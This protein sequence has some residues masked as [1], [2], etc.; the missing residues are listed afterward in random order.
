MSIPYGSQMTV[1]VHTY[2][3]TTHPPRAGMQVIILEALSFSLSLEHWSHVLQD[4]EN[5]RASIM[6]VPEECVSRPGVNSAV[7]W[8]QKGCS[9]ENT[10]KKL[11]DQ[12]WQHIK[13]VLQPS[14]VMKNQK[15]CDQPCSG[16]LNWAVWWCFSLSILFMFRLI[17][18]EDME[19]ELELIKGMPIEVKEIRRH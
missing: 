9:S 17:W 5:F 19:W 6:T 14:P 10:D 1:G 7:I 4:R 16:N 11:R 8:L 2:V 15:K 12:I 3:C 13:L 18:R